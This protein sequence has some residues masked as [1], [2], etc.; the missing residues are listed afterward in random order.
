MGHE[1]EAQ[2]VTPHSRGADYPAVGTPAPHA[3]LNMNHELK[4]AM[5]NLLFSISVIVSILSFGAVPDGT[6]DNATAI[7][8]AIEFCHKK[9]PSEKFR[10]WG[11]P[12]N[13]PNI[14]TTR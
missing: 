7:N 4:T 13:Q 3:R 2:W 6:T 1:G 5:I 12:S 10:G 9:G 14:V 11:G 8:K